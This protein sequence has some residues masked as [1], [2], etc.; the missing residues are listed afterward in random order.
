MAHNDTKKTVRAL[1]FASFFNDLGSDMIYPV[2]PL[3]LT[4]VIGANMAVGFCALPASLIAGILWD[5]IGIFIPFY[6]SLILTSLSIILL[7]FV[8]ETC[9]V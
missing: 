9:Q 4:A 6:F 7:L 1:G 5:Q 3:F 2:W 8:K